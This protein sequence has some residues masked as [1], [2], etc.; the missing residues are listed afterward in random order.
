MGSGF[1][2]FDQMI[3]SQL[4]CPLDRHRIG[5]PER[6]AVILNE[7]D[8]IFAAKLKNTG[9][10][11]RISQCM[12]DHHGLGLSLPE[13][14]LQLVCADVASDGIVINEDGDRSILKNRGNG[15]GE[16]CSHRDHFVPGHD[17]FVRRKLVRGE[18]GESDEICRRA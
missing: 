16:S 7:P 12:G 10:V 17:P 6:I 1:S 13:C 5:A 3:E 11:E 9:D 8:V 4:F 15:R 2:D 18:G 14:G